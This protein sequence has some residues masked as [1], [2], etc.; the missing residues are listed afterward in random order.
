MPT[1]W[2]WYPS[3]SAHTICCCTLRGAKIR[4]TIVRNLNAPG[5]ARPQPSWPTFIITRVTTTATRSLQIQPHLV[6]IFVYIY[7]LYTHSYS[8]SN[9]NRAANAAQP[10][11]S[12]QVSRIYDSRFRRRAFRPNITFDLCPTFHIRQLSNARTCSPQ[13]P[14]AR[15]LT[16]LQSQPRRPIS[17][18]KAKTECTSTAHNKSSST[19]PTQCWWWFRWQR[20]WNSRCSHSRNP[21]SESVYETE[22]GGGWTEMKSNRTGNWLPQWPGE[23]PAYNLLRYFWAYTEKN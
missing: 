9:S 20:I 17:N 1:P 5:K 4:S 18:Q 16:D 3:I 7:I 13:H 19:M 21:E 14:S 2:P 11:K 12:F 15:I 8:Y 10:S 6:Y 22:G 23:R